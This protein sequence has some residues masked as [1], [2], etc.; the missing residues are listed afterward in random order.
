MNQ[1][2]ELI[3]LGEVNWKNPDKRRLAFLRSNF[4]PEHKAIDR[5]ADSVRRFWNLKNLRKRKKEVKNE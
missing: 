2:Y 3:E 4:D 5:G 1:E